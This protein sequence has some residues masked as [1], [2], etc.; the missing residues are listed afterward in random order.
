MINYHNKKFRSAG[1]TANGEVTNE[2]IFHYLQEGNIV[3][4]T[5]S[6]GNIVSGQ[7]IA[8]V[9]EEGR[10]NMRYQH[11][12]DKGEVMTGICLSTPEL[13]PDGK[14]RLHESWQWT[15]G[16]QSKGQSVIEEI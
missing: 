5:Y 15:S 8:L 3:S 1:N 10:L 16:D 6:G 12:N 2:T 11:V 9:E 13:M 14:I 7:L 4:A